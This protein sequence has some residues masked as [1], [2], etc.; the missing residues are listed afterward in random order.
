MTIFFFTV[1]ISIFTNMN[2]YYSI[3]MNCWQVAPHAHFTT[4]TNLFVSSKAKMFL[5]NIYCKT[6]LV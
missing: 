1:Y 2:Y 4:C 6:L 5:S 3:I